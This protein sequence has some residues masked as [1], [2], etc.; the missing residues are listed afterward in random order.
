MAILDFCILYCR[1]FFFLLK[2]RIGK[3]YCFNIDF[4][5]E[6]ENAIEVNLLGGTMPSGA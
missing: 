4:D 1:Y 5:L 3:R 2:L 6:L